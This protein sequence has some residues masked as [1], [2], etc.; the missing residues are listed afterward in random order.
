MG[1]VLTFKDFS[2]SNHVGVTLEGHTPDTDLKHYMFF[3]NLMTIKH[4]LEEIMSMDKKKI[5]ELLSNGHDWAV[6]HLSTST[7]D[8]AEVTNWLRG[9][10]EMGGDSEEVGTDFLAKFNLDTQTGDIID[11]ETDKIVFKGSDDDKTELDMI[12]DEKED[13]EDEKEDEGEGEE[14]DEE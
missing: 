9:E 1:K 13:D 14:G 5:D 11:T 3:Q 2:K 6:D 12:D 7:D 4:Y 10:I 8:I